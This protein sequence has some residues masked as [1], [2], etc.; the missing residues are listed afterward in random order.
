MALHVGIELHAA[1]DGNGGGNVNGGIPMS[2][3][4]WLR[5]RRPANDAPG[6]AEATDAPAPSAAGLPLAEP[7]PGVPAESSAPFSQPSARRNLLCSILFVDLV[8]H[9]TRPVDEQVAAKDAL[10]RLLTRTLRGLAQG[11]WLAIDTGDGA[12]ICHAGDPAQA[13]EGALLLRKL[14][15]AYRWPRLVVRIGLHRG[16]VRVVPD[17]NKRTNVLGD[18]INVAQRVMDFALGDQVLVSREFHESIC[19]EHPGA[20]KLFR[21]LGPLQDKHGRVHEVHEV[22]T[23]QPAPQEPGR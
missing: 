18:G 3:P 13:L 16:P 11:S 4:P 17:I 2:A 9:S 7:L 20:A 19:R 22:R 5:N 6:A 8:G 10:N 14:L 12:A 15:A 21:Q 23:V 1:G